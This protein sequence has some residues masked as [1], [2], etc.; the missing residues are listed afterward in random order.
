MRPGSAVVAEGRLL[1]EGEDVRAH[2]ARL[3]VPR[4]IGPEAHGGHSGSAEWKAP[5]TT[6]SYTANHD[7]IAVPCRAVSA[8]RMHPGHAHPRDGGS[9]VSRLSFSR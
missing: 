5:W 7:T 4:A 3:A 8:V 2:S 9:T 6:F 1:L